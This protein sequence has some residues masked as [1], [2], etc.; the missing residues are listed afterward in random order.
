[1]AETKGR[2]VSFWAEE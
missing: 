2:I 1:M